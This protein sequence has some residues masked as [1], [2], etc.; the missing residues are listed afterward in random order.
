MA[1]HYWGVN[2][3]VQSI[4]DDTVTYGTSTGSTDIEVRVG[5]ALSLTR[6]DIIIGLKIIIAHLTNPSV[7]T[8]TKFPPG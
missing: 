7:I 8:G 2:R 6:E 5:D 1:D 4:R 3:G